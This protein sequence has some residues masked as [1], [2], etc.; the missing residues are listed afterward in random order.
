MWDHSIGTALCG[1]VLAE[2]RP[3]AVGELAFVGGLL[4]NVGKTVMNNECPK[5][6]LDVMKKVYNEG[7]SPLEAEI[8]VF[9]YGHPEVGFMVTEKWGL[10]ADISKITR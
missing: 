7:I 4:H 9:K 3:T 5:A 1:K 6:Y 8:A 2:G 10:P